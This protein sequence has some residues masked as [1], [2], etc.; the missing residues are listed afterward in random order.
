MKIITI[1]IKKYINLIFKK[2]K[3]KLKIVYINNL[4]IRL[5][6]RSLKRIFALK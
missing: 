6:K 2:E 4:Y 3:I 5:K 1:I